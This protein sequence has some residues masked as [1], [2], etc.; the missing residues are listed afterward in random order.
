MGREL[1]MAVVTIALRNP[2]FPPLRFL[3]FVGFFLLARD[4]LRVF[5][6]LDP[7]HKK[8]ASRRDSN[9]IQVRKL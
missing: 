5:M 9:P 7:A 2:V 4:V 6:D 8:K 1:L 3:K